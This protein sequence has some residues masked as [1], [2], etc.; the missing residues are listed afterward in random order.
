M[1]EFLAFDV[2]GAIAKRVKRLRS[3]LALP[4]ASMVRKQQSAERLRP[5]LLNF[6]VVAQMAIAFTHI[7]VSCQIVP[8]PIATPYQ[9]LIQIFNPP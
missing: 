9:Q 4:K 8:Q 6:D 5:L 2:R 1:R 7:R 3:P